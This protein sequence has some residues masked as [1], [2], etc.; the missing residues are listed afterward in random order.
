MDGQPELH[1]FVGR[2]RSELDKFPM[3]DPI[4][5]Q[6]LHM[7]TQGVG[8]SDETTEE[9]VA[10]IGARVA[11]RMAGHGPLEV[12]L[13]PLVADAEGLHLPVRPTEAV[14]EVRRTIRDAIGEVWGEDQVPEAAEGFYPHVS[15]A[16]ANTSGSPLA[17]IREI[18]NRYADVLPVTLTQ[19]ALIDLNRDEGMYRWRTV[20]S[21]SMGRSLSDQTPVPE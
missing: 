13:G 6:W 19:V 18:L 14:A 21:P 10:A 16:Y 1:E 8:F 11:G 12:Q 3:L 9:D 17:P 4:P 2:M 5:I 7:T 15:I 20:L